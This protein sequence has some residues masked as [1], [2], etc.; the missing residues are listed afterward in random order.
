MTS[1]NPLQIRQNEDIHVDFIGIGCRRCASSWLHECLNEHPEIGKPPRGIHYFGGELNKEVDWYL[2][3]LREFGDKRCVGEFSI[4]YTYPDKCARA[5]E[6]IHHFFSHAKLFM[7]I[8]NP[9]DRAYSDYLRSVKMLEIPK[10][11][12]FREAIEQNPDLL[13]R[14]CYASFL[15][16]YMEF[17]PKEQIMILFYDDLLADPA[18]YLHNLFSF[19]SVD[20]DFRPSILDKPSGSAAMIRSSM[21]SKILFRGRDLTKYVLNAAH[22]NSVVNAVRS[23]GIWRWTV[24]LNAKDQAQNEQDRAMVRDYYKNEIKELEKITGRELSHWV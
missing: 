3:R 22:M 24:A 13:E 5:A 17:F 15:K 10:S 9:I 23:T 16:K 11:I 18:S 2:D 21:I 6:E 12:S 14:G 20:P 4:S 8:R 1:D 7:T 19:L